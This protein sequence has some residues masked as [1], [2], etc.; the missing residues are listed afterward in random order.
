MYVCMCLLVIS[1]YSHDVIVLM[2]TTTDLQY[3]YID[4]YVAP[5]FRSYFLFCL[6]AIRP[7]LMPF[8]TAVITTPYSVTITWIATVVYDRET[9]TVYYG[10]DSMALV[11]TTGEMGNT[12]V[13][14]SRLLPF[15][16][17]YYI[18]SAGNSLGT[19]YTPVTTF[20]TNETGTAYGN[21][22]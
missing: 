10:T 22:I 18:I 20:I 5:G 13:T 7:P 2:T 11:N 15:T 16:T 3:F 1:P 21:S 19:T 4:T 12:K 17:Y 14:I 9:Y 6:T 8:I